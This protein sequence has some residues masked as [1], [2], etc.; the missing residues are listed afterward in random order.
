MPRHYRAH[1]VEISWTPTTARA[2]EGKAS[3][4][5]AMKDTSASMGSAIASGTMLGWADA[6]CGLWGC[7]QV[8]A[9][10]ARARS[11]Q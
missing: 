11:G 2:V 4:G 7:A 9:L 6:S 8:A 10:R 5:V 3:E 1:Q